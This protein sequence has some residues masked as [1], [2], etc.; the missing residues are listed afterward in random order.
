M[1]LG[2]HMSV[3]GGLHLAIQRIRQV[4]GTALQIFTRNQRQWQAKPVSSQEARLFAEAWQQWGPYPIA[5]HAS[6]LINL[7]AFDEGGRGKAVRALADEIERCQALA[8][9]HLVLHPGSHGGAG[10]AAAIARVA[11]SLDEAFA[12]APQA[13]R[14]LIL[15]ETTAG[16][17]TA[18]GGRFEELAAI[19][20]ASSKPARLGICLDSCHVFAAGYD[21]RDEA[22]YRRTMAE[23]GRHIGLEQLHFIHVNDSKKP[24]GS[25]VDRHE[26]IGRGEIGLEGFRLLMTDRRLA[27]IPMTLETPKGE[28]LAEDC[29]NMRI[30]RELA[31]AGKSKSRPGEA[32]P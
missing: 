20:A 3:A 23:F 5:A 25:R 11:A 17:G 21:L 10:V 28:D 6:Y 19:R 30:L 1:F 9:P 26:H 2:A 32:P 22:A 8:I 7:A 14:P 29:E 15:L 31:Q 24:L 18:L 4:Q 16:Q 27:R 13:A 12:L